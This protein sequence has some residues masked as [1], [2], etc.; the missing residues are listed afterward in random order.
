MISFVRGKL[1]RA[2]P[3]EVVIDVGGI[4]YSLNVP[5]STFETLPKVGEKVTLLTHL[6]VKEDSHT[7][8]GFRTDEERT[9]FRTIIGVSGIGPK[10]ALAILSGISIG[11]F[12]SALIE[13]S[14]DV[15]R[16]IPG[17]GKKTADRL[18]VELRDKFGPPGGEFVMP[19]GR[20]GTEE[21]LRASDAMQALISL[22]YGR[23]AAHKAISGVLK[24]SDGK[25]G[26]EQLVRE[27][28]KRV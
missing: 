10:M 5:L 25:L 20:E 27:A 15:L 4:G 28:L 21:G 13:G 17:V 26:V 6:H 9:V 11:G 18:I 23:N 12:K 2:K 8:Y 22:G 1:V 3:T 16:T 19:D 7:L 24:S 14:S